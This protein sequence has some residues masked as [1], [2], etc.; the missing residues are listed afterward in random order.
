MDGGW[1]GRWRTV[2]ID[3]VFPQRVHLFIQS[4]IPLIQTFTEYLL[5]TKSIPNAAD[6]GIIRKDRHCVY[7]SGIHSLEP[8]GE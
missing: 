7:V 5:S 8:K 6:A 1:L 3:L 2:W 4:L